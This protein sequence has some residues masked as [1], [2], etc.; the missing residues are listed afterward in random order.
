MSWN[1]L[2]R[3]SNN[4]VDRNGH[5][6]SVYDKKGYIFNP[7]RWYIYE[8]EYSYEDLSFIIIGERRNKTKYAT[9]GALG[10]HFDVSKIGLI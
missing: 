1:W 6:L 10:N 2:A 4:P 8:N 9:T 5:I 7:G 3:D